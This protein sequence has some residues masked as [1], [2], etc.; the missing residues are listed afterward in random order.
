[1]AVRPMAAVLGHMESL[2][3]IIVAEDLLTIR[4]LIMSCE[5]SRLSPYL[6]NWKF[7][8]VSCRLESKITKTSSTFQRVCMWNDFM[9]PNLN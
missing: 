3:S 9:K 7:K 4:V 8:L 2:T 5:N 6:I 1:M